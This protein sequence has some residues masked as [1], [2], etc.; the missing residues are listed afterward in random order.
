MS[1]VTQSRGLTKQMY[2]RKLIFWSPFTGEAGMVEKEAKQLSN[3][4]EMPRLPERHPGNL[5]PASHVPALLPRTFQ[6]K[7]Y[8]FTAEER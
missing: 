3:L 1:G 7:D 8:C 6:W 5:P 2:T 4:P